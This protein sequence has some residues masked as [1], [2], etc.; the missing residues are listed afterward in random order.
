MRS[1]MEAQAHTY[2]LLKF[3]CVNTI[4]MITI[5]EKTSGSLYVY[6][7]KRYNSAFLYFICL[8]VECGRLWCLCRV[9]L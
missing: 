8:C 4:E 5:A 7:R 1:T 9:L 3:W 6:A 2:D